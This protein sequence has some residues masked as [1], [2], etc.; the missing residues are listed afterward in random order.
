MKKARTRNFAGRAFAV[1]VAL[2]TRGCLGQPRCRAT[3]GHKRRLLEPRQHQRWALARHRRASANVNAVYA[4]RPCLDRLGLGSAP[5]GSASRRPQGRRQLPGFHPP[6]RGAP[7]RQRDAGTTRPGP[8]P[9][10]S[11][12][13]LRT[14]WSRAGSRPRAVPE[15]RDA[16]TDGSAGRRRY[17][18]NAP[19][20]P[21]RRGRAR[22][23]AARS[24]RP[25]ERFLRL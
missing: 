22:V 23:A 15:Q 17:R 16:A 20:W 3:R 8:R 21:S 6:I 10:C 13:S 25:W 2:R 14:I 7:E 1:P 4:P 11:P 5:P 24:S 12:D 18:R 9:F 19:A